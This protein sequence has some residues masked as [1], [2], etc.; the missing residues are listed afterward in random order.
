MKEC[1][2]SEVEPML[3]NVMIRHSESTALEENP[4]LACVIMKSRGSH[5]MGISQ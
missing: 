4:F 2:I 3:I 5:E 1:S